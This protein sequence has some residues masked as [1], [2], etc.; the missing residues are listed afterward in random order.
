ML[1]RVSS[2]SGLIQQVTKRATVGGKARVITL[3]PSPKPRENP[4]QRRRRGLVKC[5]VSSQQ[6]TGVTVSAGTRESDQQISEER[7]GEA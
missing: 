6:P 3:A 1:V 5:R 7:K 2:T 4:F